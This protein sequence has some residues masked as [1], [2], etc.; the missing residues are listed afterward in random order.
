MDL[1]REIRDIIYANAMGS[2]HVL[3]AKNEEIRG[4]QSVTLSLP[5]LEVSKGVSTG[6]TAIFYAVNTFTMSSYAVFSI[7]FV[8]TKNAALFRKV[9]SRFGDIYSWDLWSLEYSSMT[10]QDQF[11][12]L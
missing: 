10:E 3:V 4:S 7:P 9:V 5:L 6:A 12:H 11:T 8:S 1:S 2:D